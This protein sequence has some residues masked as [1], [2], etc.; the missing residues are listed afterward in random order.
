MKINLKPQQ[1]LA[2]F[3][4]R[5]S[6][7]WEPQYL[8]HVS[9]WFEHAPFAFWI[10]EILRPRQFVELGTHTGFS[11]FCF[12]QAVQKLGFEGKCA[13]IDTWKGDEHSFFYGEEIYEAVILQNSRYNRFSKLIRSTFDKALRKFPDKSINLLHIDGRHFYEDVKHD[14]ECWLPKLTD[15]GVVLFHDTQVRERDFGVWKL[16]EE[17]NRKHISFEFVH[18]H[19]LGVLIPNKMPKALENFFSASATEVQ[20]A[21]AS[22]GTA[23]SNRWLLLDAQTKLEKAQ[24]ELKQV[25]SVGGQMDK[26]IEDKR[27]NEDSLRNLRKENRSLR[28]AQKTLQEQLAESVPVHEFKQL[29][30][31]VVIQKNANGDQKVVFDAIAKLSQEIHQQRPLLSRF[32]SVVHSAVNSS[33]AQKSLLRKSIYFD[34]DWYLKTYKDVADSGMDPAKHFL[35]CGA[36]EGRDPGPYFST[37]GYQAK[38][39]E[40]L[41]DGQN[42]LLHQFKPVWRKSRKSGPL[43]PID[44]ITG[45][46]RTAI[47][48]HI[49]A[50]SHKPLISVVL[51]VY[52]TPENFLRQAIGSVQGQLYP[53]WELCIAN[54]CSPNADVA[55]VLEE[56]A[57]RDKR[58]KIVHRLING[59]IS[60][61]TNSALE[62]ATGE[63]IALMDHDDLL[64]ET[65]LYEVAVEIGEHPETDVIYSDEDQI[66]EQ[67]RRS[68][69]YHKTD[70]NPELL[71]GQNMV[72][73]LGI[74]RTSLIKEIGGLRLGFEGSQDFDLILRAWAASSI[75]RIRHIP[76]ILYHWRRGTST[77]SFS[78]SQLERCTKAARD[79]I[80]EF[81][82]I[83]GEGAKVIAAPTIGNFSRIVR[84][85]PNPAPLVSIVV[86]TKDQ[87]ELLNVCTNGILENTAYP[88]LELII[89]DHDSHEE[90]TIRL[91]EKLKSDARVR[92]LPFKGEFNYSKMNNLAANKAK[93]SI[94]ALVNN[95]IEIIDPSWLNELVS[96]AIRSEIGAVGAKLI[97]PDGRIQ[98]AGVVVGLGA[99]AGHAFHFSPRTNPGYLG[100]AMLTRAIS[101]V[102]GACLVVRKSVYMEVG[103]LNEEH[104]AVAFN[105]VDLCL[106]IQAKGYRNVWTPFAELIH[107][108]SVSRG[109]ENTKEKKA[110]FNRD[111]EYMF[112]NWQSIYDN[113]PYYNSNLTRNTPNYDVANPSRRKKPWAYFLK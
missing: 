54:D 42:P 91:F 40:T 113:D 82:D 30:Q 86:P 80:Q 62:L 47:K 107:H 98:H 36:R 8:A 26:L 87:A 109:R 81:L 4:F 5:S 93:G 7:L 56:C 106:K 101:A 94:L 13:A 95:D 12:C 3:P 27:G 15:D 58:I 22:L 24:T 64:H 29:Q 102:T 90:K 25:T 17:L 35:E 92:I 11:Y 73:H 19:G 45:A 65:A 18:G 41:G 46:D 59:N 2:G 77:S 74:Y 84:K 53:N 79:A 103:G 44:D 110:R 89:V 71:L 100:Q 60:A 28:N 23:V 97:Y 111:T 67:G 85:I 96:N 69:G 6:M 37:R 112:K 70:F 88:N 61:A 66:D 99:F 14:Y 75:T 51:P 63:F 10:T 39:P 32:K 20:L 104:L 57:A 50:L 48:K 49:S 55:K 83:E 31:A 52:N 72:S 78:E 76:A 1:K 108:E 9:A 38:H 43:K 105:D 16:F 21:F 68:G 34:S 33:A